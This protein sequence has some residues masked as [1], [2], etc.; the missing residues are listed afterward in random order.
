MTPRQPD[1]SPRLRVIKVGG[2]LLD[3]N[4]LSPAL[5]GWLARQPPAKHVLLAGGGELAEAL[6]KLD[7]VHGL[8]GVRAHWL[9]I[10]ALSV[11]ARV[12]ATILEDAPLHDSLDQVRAWATSIA[13]P[14]LCVFD[15]EPLLTGDEPRLGG[16]VLPRGWQVTS[17][18]ISAR[19]AELLY[20]DELVLL[21][22]TLPVELDG[23]DGPNVTA[24]QAARQKF[25]DAHF[26][27]AILS[28]PQVRWVNLRAYPE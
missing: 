16:T 27:Q 22:S 8:D 23:S 24:S 15:C 10:R 13:G 12:L 3:W 11:T 14:A 28:I 21:K 19:L 20:A 18:S 4:D 2:S 26:P 1:E 25:V 17:D 9:C 6:R 5:N 7:A